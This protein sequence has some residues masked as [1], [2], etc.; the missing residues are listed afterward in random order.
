MSSC[1]RI[2]P[3]LLVGDGRC[4]NLISSYATCSISGQRRPTSSRTRWPFNCLPQCGDF[5]DNAY[6]QDEMALIL[7]TRKLLGLPDLP[8]TA[9]A[10]YVPL[11]HSHSASVTL[12]TVQPLSVE[13]ARD[14][15]R[16]GAWYRARGRP[17]AS[18]LPQAIRASGHDEVFVGRLRADLSVPHGLH[19]WVVT[20][21]LRKGAALNACTDR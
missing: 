10:A 19:L 7:E 11:A 4:R 5:L 18:A 14:A 16:T 1:L 15:A 13:T 12:E 6:T 2:K 20:D 17:D 21:N 9:T 8:I 3:S